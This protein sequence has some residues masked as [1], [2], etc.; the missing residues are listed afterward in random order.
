MT[1]MKAF[2]TVGLVGADAERAAFESPPAYAPS[3]TEQTT[4]D[5]FEPEFEP[6]SAEPASP[7]EPTVPAETESRAENQEEFYDLW[8]ECC[9]RVPFERFQSALYAEGYKKIA[10]LQDVLAET[11]EE[12]DHVFGTRLVCDSDGLVTH[13]WCMVR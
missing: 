11:D 2:I 10:D 9:R 3:R 7:A 4:F 1:A 6:T 13:T 5:K 12:Y 8:Y